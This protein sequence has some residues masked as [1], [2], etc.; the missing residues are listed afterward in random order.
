MFDLVLYLYVWKRHANDEVTGPVAAA[1]EGEGCWPRSLA[2]QFGHYEP[3]NGTWTNLKEAHKQENCRH[4][5]ITHPG[6]VI[7]E[8]NESLFTLHLM[9]A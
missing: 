4:T 7:L 6:E 3:R 8:R 2:E 1:C 5:D 9:L